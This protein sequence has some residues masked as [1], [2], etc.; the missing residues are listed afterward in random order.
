M[1]IKKSMQSAFLTLAFSASSAYANV[2]MVATQAAFSSL[3]TITQNTNFDAY[4]HGSHPGSNFTVGAFTF[5]P[6]PEGENI[7]SGTGLGFPRNLLTDEFVQGTMI[8][9]S[10]NSNLFAF[11]T[12][13]FLGAGN[14]TFNIATNLGSYVFTEA[15]PIGDSEFRF[16]GFEAGAGEYFTSVNVS[17]EHQTGFTDVQ[18]GN[19]RA[20][21]TVP[22]PASLALLG[23]GIAALVNNRRKD[24]PAM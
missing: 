5:V 4:S 13:N 9:I 24:K 6:G 8:Q 19:T 11:N 17:G 23:L 3:G 20:V 2:T 15:V 18:A 21:T 7:I 14:A 12:A 10:G 1:H 16:F 22:E